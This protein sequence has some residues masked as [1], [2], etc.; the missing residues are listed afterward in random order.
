MRLKKAAL[1]I[2]LVLIVDQI[3]KIYIKT[4]FK[5]QDSIEIFSWFELLFVENDYHHKSFFTQVI[6]CKSQQLAPNIYVLR[7]NIMYI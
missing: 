1:L 2:L 5:L 6:G 4:N 3:L 7:R